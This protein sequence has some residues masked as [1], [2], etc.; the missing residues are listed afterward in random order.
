MPTETED[1]TR[2]MWVRWIE[3]YTPAAFFDAFMQT[4]QG[5]ESR[6]IH[7]RQVIRLDIREGGGVPDWGI[8]GDYG[9]ID[10]PDTGPDGTGGHVAAGT[11][12]DV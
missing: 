12:G 7:C 6:C 1:A 2:D 10:S 11:D 5:A 4:A 8:D 9:C 3:S